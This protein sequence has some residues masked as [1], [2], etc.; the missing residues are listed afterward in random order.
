MYTV[1]QSD[2]DN[3]NGAGSFFFSSSSF[4]ITQTSTLSVLASLPAALNVIS[5][6]LNQNFTENHLNFQENACE[7]FID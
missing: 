1:A 7:K 3:E 5:I 4:H 6:L 2:L